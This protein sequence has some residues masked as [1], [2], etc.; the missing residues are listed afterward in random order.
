MCEIILNLSHFSRIPY[1]WTNGKQVGLVLQYETWKHSYL[2]FMFYF[3]FK[4]SLLTRLL[5]NANL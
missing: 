1:W 5:T 3:I 4:K 2:L